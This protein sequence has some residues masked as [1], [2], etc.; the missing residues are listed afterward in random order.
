MREEPQPVAFI[1]ASA[2]APARD[3]SI[4]IYL[5]IGSSF[6]V[7]EGADLVHGL[8]RLFLH[9]P[10]TGAGDD[11]AFDVGADLAHD[12]GLLVTK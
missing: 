5:P 11:A 12:R 9:D 2:V 4:A 3:F 10:V 7:K 1:I 6:S 8:G